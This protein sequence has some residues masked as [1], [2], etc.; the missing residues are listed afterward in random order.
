MKKPVKKGIGLFIVSILILALTT[1]TTLRNVPKEIYTNRDEV[2]VM[3]TIPK[4]GPFNSLKY[5]KE[6]L[7]INFLGFIPIKSIAIHKLSDIEVIPGGS[8]IGVKLS[9]EGVLVVGFSDIIVNNQKVESPAKLAGIEIGDIILK[10]NNVPIEESRELIKNIS[11]MN[12]ENIE[13]LIKR[14]DE[15]INKN[16]HLIKEDD[17][18][19]KI[20]LWVRDSTAGVGTLTFYHEESG[21]FGALGHPVTD[22]DTN[23]SFMIKDGDLL[24]ASVI[25]VRKGEKGSPGEL[26]GIFVD[27]NNPIGV[28]RKNTECGIF[29][30]YSR[31][32]KDNLRSTST[33]MKVGFRDE[34]KVGKAKI[35]TT[36]DEY[37]P[38][39][40]E[41]EIMKIFQQDEPSSKSML[42]KVT[43]EELLSKTGGIVQGMSG[44]PIIQDNK[45]VGAVTHVL[46]NK[47]DVG[48]GI[49][50]DWMLKDAGVIN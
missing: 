49:Y 32:K 12:C 47:P 14:N 8:S 10:V 26:R 21:K 13:L 25:S 6:K 33:K 50:I 3:A 43:D 18:V 39:E 9:S 41:I 29:G 42:I 44:S 17:T 35:I 30:D 5:S 31:E 24:E 15:I 19:Y 40:Y 4:V 23:K 7:K 16:F 45:V 11:S 38:K 27:S 28:I 34:I 36:I 37:G 2:S 22:V 46:I 20:G 1:A 48:Y